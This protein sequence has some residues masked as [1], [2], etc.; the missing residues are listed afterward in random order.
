M[1]GDFMAI[2]AGFNVVGARRAAIGRPSSSGVKVPEGYYIIEVVADALLFCEHL[3]RAGIS[4]Q[5][6]LGHVLRVGSVVVVMIPDDTPSWTIQLCEILDPVW[7]ARRGH[8]PLYAVLTRQY[9]RGRHLTA[10]LPE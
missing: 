3:A 2:E 6:I 5:W 7:G 10:P 4:E 8:D 9:W 1:S